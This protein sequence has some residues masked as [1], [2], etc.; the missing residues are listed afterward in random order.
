MTVHDTR[1]GPRGV[2]TTPRA[3]VSPLGCGV[4]VNVAKPGEVGCTPST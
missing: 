4:T 1:I 3:D 2:G